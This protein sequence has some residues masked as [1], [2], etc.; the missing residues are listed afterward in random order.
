MGRKKKEKIHLYEETWVLVVSMF[1]FRL[2]P[3][4]CPSANTSIRFLNSSKQAKT[5][6][7]LFGKPHSF[8]MKQVNTNSTRKLDPSPAWNL[9]WRPLC[10]SHI[11]LTKPR[12]AQIEDGPFFHSAEV[13]PYQHKTS[14]LPFY[15]L[16][17]LASRCLF[18][19]KHLFNKSRSK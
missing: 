19:A 9:L 6:I 4:A 11:A 18:P 12:Y 1:L 15:T 5:S 17:M 10:S 2:F 13:F 14:R 7:L 3:L 8:Q 16:E